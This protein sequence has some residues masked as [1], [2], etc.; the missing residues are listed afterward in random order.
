MTL[1]PGDQS[2]GWRRRWEQAHRELEALLA[3][4]TEPMSADSIH[5]ARHRLHSFYVQTY[6][7]KDALIA[8]EASTGVSRELIEKAIT[9]D[10]DLALLAD[11]ANLDKHGKLTKPPRSGHVPIIRS[12]EGDA[13]DSA[14][15]GWRLR[16]TVDHGGSSLDGL[17]IAQEAIDAW[18]RTLA[19]WGLI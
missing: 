8:E 14:M 4:S 16:L 5:A 13:E 9:D 2:R 6:H 10:P 17:D 12:V 3:P 7:L 11:L 15:R 1:K 18:R 19:S